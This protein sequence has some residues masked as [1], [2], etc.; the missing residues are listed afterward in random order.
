MDAKDKISD[1]A[2]GIHD[3]TLAASI[4]KNAQY[5]VNGMLVGAVTGFFLAMI[6]GRCKICLSIWGAAGGGATGYLI[7]TRK[8]NTQSFCTC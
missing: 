4:K 5:T 1:I 2:A 7:A 6:T 3:G 8:K